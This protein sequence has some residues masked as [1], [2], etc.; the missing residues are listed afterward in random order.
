MKYYFL[1]TYLPDIHRDDK[2]IKIRFGDLLDERDN[3]APLDWLQVEFLLLA[4]DIF[5]L[6]RLL[7]GKDVDVEHTS[8]SKEY[9][10]D[11]VKAPKEA[12]S[13]LEEFLKEVKEEGFGPAE[14]DRLYGIYYDYILGE[15][16]SSLLRDYF[17]FERDL[18]NVLAAI[19]AR[20]LGL[21]PAEVL[22]GEGELVEQLG[23][24][25]ADDFGLGQDMPWINRLLETQDPLR[26]ED[27]VE[28]ILWEYIE[29][30]SQQDHFEFDVVLAYLLRLQL[31]EK[32][33][34]LSEERGME[35]VRQLEEL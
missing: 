2:K 4:R 6:E 12:P 34:A 8:Y 25:S 29:E 3:M 30:R 33:L 28:E 16:S 19:R 10:V 18:R 21:P 24:S 7:S 31:L 9:W 11:Q 17:L 13:F 14:V 35:I 1:V 20:R 26:L 5:L 22:L 32:R 27:T 15:T 23:R